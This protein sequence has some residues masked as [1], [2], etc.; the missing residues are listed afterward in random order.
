VPCGKS[1]LLSKPTG[2]RSY[3]PRRVATGR[4]AWGSV[5]KFIAMDLKKFPE[6]IPNRLRL[7]CNAHVEAIH[8]KHGLDALPAKVTTS[9]Y[10]ATCSLMDD[11]AVCLRE[12]SAYSKAR[13]LTVIMGVAWLIPAV[14]VSW[15]ALAGIVLCAIVIK[16]QSRR[17]FDRWVYLG[18]VL[19][20]MEALA[21]NFCGW[22]D[23]YPELGQQAKQ[24]LYHDNPETR[25]TFFLDYYLPQRA[26]LLPEFI[27]L[28]SP[29]SS[30]P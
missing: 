29:Q 19:L 7:V 5:R 15:W 4:S 20:S 6:S 25:K 24:L 11:T 2:T 22:A 8:K 10:L 30:G 3:R 12:I 13:V 14:L 23:V 9:P 28:F 18:S 27:R 17:I 1:I 21:T 26:Q 16:Y